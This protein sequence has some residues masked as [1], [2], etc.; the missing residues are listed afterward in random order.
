MEWRQGPRNKRAWGF[1]ATL[2]LVLS[3][4]A[5]GMGYFASHHIVRPLGFRG[6]VSIPARG[7]T[8]ELEGDTCVGIRKDGSRAHCCIGHNT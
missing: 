3:L 4:A 7:V 8:V 1:G 2:A 5:I 6:A